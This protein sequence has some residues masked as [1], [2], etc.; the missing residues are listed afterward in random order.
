MTKNQSAKSIIGFLVLFAVFGASSLALA[1]QIT[2]S[3]DPNSESDLG[4]YK[5]YYGT[6]SRTYGTPIDVGNVTTYPLAG[7]T[8]GQ[9]YFITVTAY[10]QSK[11]ESS[12]SNEVSGVAT[13]PIQTAVITV[14]TSPAGLQIG[15]DGTSYTAPQTFTWTVGSSHTLSVSSPLSGTSGTQY[16]YSSW[17][18]GGA[19]NHSVTV[20]SSAT[21]YTASFTTQ[22]LLTTAVSPSGSGTVTANP[23]ATNNWYNSGQS[24]QVTASPGTGYSFSSWSGSLS[25]STNPGSVTMSAP[26]S[27]TANFTAIPETVS[28]PST[29]SGTASGTI[30]T[31]YSYSTGNASSNFSH[32]VQY[33]FDWGDGTTSSWSSATS[34]TKSW[35]SAGTY[36]VKAQARCGTH[37]SVVSGWSSS[38]SVVISPAPVSCTVTTSPS[39]LQ[40]KVDGTSY[41]AP[42]SFSWVPG[43]SHTIAVSSPL[44]GASGTQYVY[45]SWSDGGAQN[46]SV[47]VPFSSATTYTASFTT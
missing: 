25:G 40:V 22:Y 29:P 47:T 20:P 8:Q 2:L 34:A 1:A 11:N 14:T 15:V 46:H 16:V 4:G 33:Q 43:S 19:Q 30:G 10:D 31:S 23:S 24:V 5:V 13:N 38:L 27:V 28:A 3:W 18:D 21:T 45:S 41:T 35:S 39:G 17:S 32:A 7:L 44:N 42:Q 37:T 6:A 9:T 12:Y 26:R 36:S